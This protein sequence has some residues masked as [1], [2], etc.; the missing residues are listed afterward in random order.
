MLEAPGSGIYY[1]PFLHL[2]HLWCDLIFWLTSFGV[3]VHLL[4][5]SLV[6]NSL[7]SQSFSSLNGNILFDTQPERRLSFKLLYLPDM[8]KS[9]VVSCVN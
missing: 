5:N 8:K 9:T 3:E 7:S 2:D 4:R 1:P 6:P